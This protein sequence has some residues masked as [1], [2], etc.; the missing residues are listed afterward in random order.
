MIRKE[1]Y[2]IFRIEA[3]NDTSS[4]DAEEANYLR[5]VYMNDLPQDENV[6][7]AL[8]KNLKPSYHESTKRFISQCIIS[9]IIEPSPSNNKIKPFSLFPLIV[10]DNCVEFEDRIDFLEE[11][12]KCEELC[13]LFF[14]PF[15][16]YLS[17]CC[18]RLKITDDYSIYINFLEVVTSFKNVIKTLEDEKYWGQEKDERVLNNQILEE[19]E[20]IPISNSMALDVSGFCSSMLDIGNT[21]DS[22]KYLRDQSQKAKKYQHLVFGHRDPFSPVIQDIDTSIETIFLGSKISP[23]GIDYLVTVY[24]RYSKK[25]KFY[26][27]YSLGK[28]FPFYRSFNYY[29]PCFLDG[30]LELFF[31]TK[32]SFDQDREELGKMSRIQLYQYTTSNHIKLDNLARSL[33]GVIHSMIAYSTQI[34]RNFMAYVSQVSKYNSDRNKLY[35]EVQEFISDGYAFNMNCLLTYFNKKIVDNHLIDKINSD[36]VEK[37]TE[38]FVTFC[39][40]E[41]IN[42]MRLS[43]IKFMDYLET[44]LQNL[45]GSAEIEEREVLEGGV[46]FWNL[47]VSNFGYLKGEENFILFAADYTQQILCNW[48][49]AIKNGQSINLLNENMGEHRTQVSGDD[50]GQVGEK[51]RSVTSGPHPGNQHPPSSSEKEGSVIPGTHSRNQQPPSS[52]EREGGVT[53][54]T[55]SGN[56]HSTSSG[57]KEGSVIPGTHS[58]NQ[59]PPSSTD[60]SE[61][62]TTVEKDWPEEYYIVLY[63]MIELVGGRKSSFIPTRAV[64]SLLEH[65]CERKPRALMEYLL[66]I[67]EL[68]PTAWSDK[69]IDSTIEYY[70]SIDKESNKGR[71]RNR[72]HLILAQRNDF[73]ASNKRSVKFIK[74]MMHDFG[75]ALSEG[76]NDIM[77]IKSLTDTIEKLKSQLAEMDSN[78]SKSNGGRV[79]QGTG[80]F[81]MFSGGATAAHG[82]VNDTSV[83]R[84]QQGAPA[85]GSQGGVNDTSV[86]RMHQGGVNDTSVPR[87]N[88]GA[89]A[90]GNQ[91][92]TAQGNQGAPAQGNQSVSG[93][94]LQELRQEL[95]AKEK[96]LSWTTKNAQS[97]FIYVK[98]NFGL[99]SNIISTTPGVLLIKEIRPDFVKILNSILKTIVGPRCVNLAIKNPDTYKFD[100]KDLLRRIILVYI[101]IK[102]D[103]FVEEVGSEP[104]Y[105]DIQ[106]F[107]RSLDICERKYILNDSQIMELKEFI[108]KLENINITDVDDDFPPEFTD[109]VTFNFIR[110][111]VRL[112]T[113]KVTVDRSTYNMIML[114]DGID[115]FSRLPLSDDLIALD[116]EMTAKVEKYLLEKQQD[117][118][119]D[120]SESTTTGDT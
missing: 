55:H 82:G 13:E 106:Y 36:G 29:F 43:N 109:P 80:Q 40:F 102:D 7:I 9:T 31:Y 90:Q 50:I 101:S 96:V 88:G 119:P 84:M 52:G 44:L 11:L 105:Y 67:A 2:E 58:G 103:R 113:S 53:Q 24:K 37:V 49:K 19:N 30:F 116:E 41:K 25:G 94:N 107:K 104:M 35:F 1:I 62:N 118:T 120:K 63:R 38:S 95:S 81:N 16:Y 98:N 110:N 10:E 61:N 114:N 76:L 42:F 70:N 17:M 83:S 39:Y 14:I 60:L 57:E 21:L 97:R 87:S 68:N 77:E 75:Q 100:P 48:K 92:T 12:S 56:Q 66:S 32:E 6:L 117:T 8:Y 115:P 74:Y 27:P 111:P 89:P 34:K 99:L 47:F 4:I 65:T 3:D 33:H 71:E 26:E 23:P 20:T 18:S 22:H 91:G 78:T 93:T 5:L 112:L 85:H 69:M 54:G 108:G 45:H 59:H 46:N 79:S 15:L 28:E 72:I 64:I 73:I 86:S 51:E